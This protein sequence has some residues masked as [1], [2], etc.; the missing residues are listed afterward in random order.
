MSNRRD[1]NLRELG[2][3]SDD[4]NNSKDQKSR[5]LRTRTRSIPSSPAT[6]SGWPR[7]DE[8]AAH[9]GGDPW[10]S[11][12][13]PWSPGVA[14]PSPLSPELHALATVI[15]GDFHNRLDRLEANQ[16]HKFDTNF[17][18]LDKSLRDYV[19]AR[20][21]KLDSNHTTLE[22][23]VLAMDEAQAKL[24][25]AVPSSPSAWQTHSKAETENG[26]AYFEFDKTVARLNSTTLVGMDAVK[27]LVHQLAREA[28]V[29]EDT[30][31][32]KGG[33]LSRRFRIC[34]EGS[35][36]ELSGRRCRKLLD[37]LKLG[38]GK[39]RD[40]EVTRPDGSL[41]RVFISPDKSQAAVRTEMAT[42]VLGLATQ[43]L[44]PAAGLTTLKKKTH[45]RIWL[46]SPRGGGVR[47]LQGGRPCQLGP[48]SC[49]SCEGRHETY[50]LSLRRAA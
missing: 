49:G 41:E 1:N 22:K 17:D 3:E 32:I 30:F 28:D 7:H 36:T 31:S 23:R 35:D 38:N 29:K 4:G 45:H 15:Q 2:D 5:R 24:H 19:G 43:E 33:A 42:K 20:C 48:R 9:A 14:V 10:R 40:T 37:S 6:G 16:N 25:E 46:E 26:K 8:E 47:S 39:W 50:L 18:Q 11:G 21:D 34:F 13:D 44:F 27:T 12:G